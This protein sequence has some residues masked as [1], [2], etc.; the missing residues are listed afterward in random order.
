MS[1]DWLLFV[2]MG[3]AFGIPFFSIIR[4]YLY[5]VRHT[6]HI[7][8]MATVVRVSTRDLRVLQHILTLVGILGTAA[9]PSLI[10]VVWNAFSLGEALVPLYLITALPISV[11]T[12]IKIPFIFAINK[13]VRVVF[14][15]HL[16]RIFYW[17]F[18]NKN[19]EKVVS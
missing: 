9:L 16:R 2:Y 14:S 12:N 4:I 7:N 18:K 8:A 11:F 13:K 15:N 10:L 3:T 5:I 6:R 19:K 17:F 1:T